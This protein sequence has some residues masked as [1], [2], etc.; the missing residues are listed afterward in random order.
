MKTDSKSGNRTKSKNWR[1]METQEKMRGDERINS[2]D[3]TSN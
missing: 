1:Q 3:P 2:R